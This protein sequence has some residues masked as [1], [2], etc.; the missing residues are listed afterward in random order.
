MCDGSTA[1]E[2][3]E[4][5]KRAPRKFCMALRRNACEGIGLQKE[6]S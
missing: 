1:A 2:F 3:N 6:V 4:G 5:F